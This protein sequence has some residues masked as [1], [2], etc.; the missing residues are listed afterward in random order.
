[1]DYVCKIPCG[2]GGGGCAGEQ[3]HFWPAVFIG[4]SYEI[5]LSV[6]F[7]RVVQSLVIKEPDIA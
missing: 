5:Q 3:G 2:G 1:M 6:D 4:H 7:L